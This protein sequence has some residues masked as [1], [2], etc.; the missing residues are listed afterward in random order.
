[1]TQAPL[2]ATK[3]LPGWEQ[4]LKWVETAL[5]RLYI[6]MQE[7]V[8][9]SEMHEARPRTLPVQKSEPGQTDQSPRPSGCKYSHTDWTDKGELPDTY[10]DTSCCKQTKGIVSW[11]RGVNP[12]SG[13]RQH[14]GTDTEKVGRYRIPPVTLPKFKK[15]EGGWHLDVTW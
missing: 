2:P 11:P 1:M 12:W 10:W 4:L 6:P 14:W 5:E 7:G 3:T 9:I 8:H 13:R 15:A